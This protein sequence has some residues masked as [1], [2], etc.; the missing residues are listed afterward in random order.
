MIYV[1]ILVLIY[2]GFACD[3]WVGVITTL[4]ALGFLIYKA[5]PTF[6]SILGN[7]AYNSDNMEKTQKYYDKATGTGRASAAICT[8]YVLMLMRMGEIDKAYKICANAIANPKFKKQEK[9]VLKEYRTLIFFK[10]GNAEE[11]LEDAREIFAA[12]KNTTIYSL[13]GYLMLACDEPIDETLEFCLEAYDFNSDDRDIVDNLALAY[14][15]KGDL[16]KAK[17]LCDTLLEMS[18]TF[19]EAQYHSALIAKAMGDVEKAKEHIANID[20]CIRTAL[21]TVSEEEIATL[22]AELSEVGQ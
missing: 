19:V 2:F 6:Y 5:T 20:D 9:F 4:I 21:T 10:Q 18:P 12:Y 1:I 7:R 13:L 8:T 16:E 11:A 3:F 17:E 14:Y 15:K 22:K